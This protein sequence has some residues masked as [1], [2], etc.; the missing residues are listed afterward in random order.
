MTKT[1][2]ILT[3]DIVKAGEAMRVVLGMWDNDVRQWMDGIPHLS[4]QY[5]WEWMEKFRKKLWQG[6]YRDK[7]AEHAAEALL[8]DAM[9]QGEDEF[10]AAAHFA[11]SYRHYSG[12]CHGM[13]S[14]RVGWGHADYSDDSFSD[15][16]DAL[17]VIGK[18]LLDRLQAG[19]F[20]GMR[21]DGRQCVK[22]WEF[23]P[24]VAK[25]CPLYWE[26]VL[27][28]ENYFAMSLEDAVKE[29]LT[30][31]YFRREGK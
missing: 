20:W 24:E 15:L 28:G 5:F 30:F 22:M 7:I 13:C 19:D 10:A 14:P 2:S 17:P 4:P 8:Y 29:K 1:T 23:K 11:I 3:D 12:L 31:V 6:G 27:D 9:Q 26:K 21:S 16:C 18:E 25:A